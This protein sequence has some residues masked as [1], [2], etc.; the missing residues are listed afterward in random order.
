MLKVGLTG[1]IG[2]GKTV[3]ANIFRQ[4]SVPVYDADKEARMLTETNK[5]IKEKILAAFGSEIFN[6][7]K[8]LNR[9]KLGAVVFSDKEKLSR[10]NEI[11]HPVVKKHFEKWLGQN[12]K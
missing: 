5:E 9:G 2:S 1:G 3:V 4:L 11:I 12:E 6:D 7:D 8:S 10:L